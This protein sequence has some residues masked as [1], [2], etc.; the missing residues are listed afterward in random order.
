M[1]KEEEE[2]KIKQGDEAELMPGLE[3][4]G[5]AEEQLL[6]DEGFG[7]SPH[8]SA[9]FNGAAHE[10]CMIPA[11]GFPGR[12]EPSRATA[13]SMELSVLRE[14]RQRY[15]APVMHSRF[16]QL[17]CCCSDYSGVVWRVVGFI[18]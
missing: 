7:K 13:L 4:W 14:K 9:L 6:P 1:E 15:C 10:Y 5:C 2:E 16:L 3:D 11:Q 8:S 12:A 17:S 18:K